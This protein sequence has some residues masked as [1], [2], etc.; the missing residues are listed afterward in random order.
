MLISRYLYYMGRKVLIWKKQNMKVVKDRT[1]TKKE[2][3]THLGKERGPKLR[4]AFQV[5]GRRERG[6]GKRGRGC[7]ISVWW[8]FFSYARHVRFCTLV[9]YLQLMLGTCV[10]R[11]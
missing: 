1:K 7:R 5:W 3:A 8:F 11:I 9:Q 10:L 4:S 6:G 2:K